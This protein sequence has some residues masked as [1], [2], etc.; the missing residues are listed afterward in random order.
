MIVV[1]AAGLGLTSYLSLVALG[2]SS[3]AGCGAG[4]IFDCAHV[5][6]SKWA[7][8]FGVPVG[9][10]AA[11]LYGVTLASLT[12]T[13]VATRRWVRWATLTLTVVASI[14]AGLAAIWF[15][16]LQ[17]MVLQHL[18]PWCLAAHTCGLILAGMTLWS[19]PLGWRH[20]LIS[21]TLSFAGVGALVTAQLMA[22]EAA[23]YEIQRHPVDTPVAPGEAENTVPMD[24]NIFEAPGFDTPLEDPGSKSRDENIFEAPAD[25]RS[26]K[27][28]VR[29]DSTRSTET[30]TATIA[31]LSPLVSLLA[32]PARH[33]G[34][35]RQQEEQRETAGTHSGADERRLI[36]ISDRK[37]QLDVAQWP[38]AGV[39]TAENVLVEMFDYT[40]PHCRANHVAVH[41]AMEKLG[42]DKLAI[43]ALIVPMNSGCNDT[44]R[45]SDPVHA[46]ACELGRLSV[47]VWLVDPEKFTEFHE[48]MFQGDA[49]PTAVEAQRQANRLVDAT[50]LKRVLSEDITNQ[51][52][53]RQIELYKAVGAGAVPKMFFKNTT[54][55]GKIDSAAAVEQIIQQ[56]NDNR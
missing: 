46:E 31:I 23:T 54:V 15:I 10:P 56:S 50:Q 41:E 17:F 8:V 1:A 25:S 39:P 49:V 14:A 26:F 55:T 4:Q 24:E 11:V 6:N 3:I 18:C 35:D 40:C 20:T 45:N 36:S 34:I 28:T 53:A 33:P 5:M 16:G 32:M 47:A 42:R 22:G 12:G 19:R 43:V 37:I 52:L 29:F 44:V 38:L 51:Y 7:K 48:W 21:G 2:S 9:I 27:Q 30:T 13:M